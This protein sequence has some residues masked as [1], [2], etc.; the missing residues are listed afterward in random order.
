MS[1]VPR[2]AKRVPRPYRSAGPKAR[3]LKAILQMIIAFTAMI[4]LGIWLIAMMRGDDNL[5]SAGE[6]S[7]GLFTGIGLA[8]AGAAVI[9]LAY[10]LYTD[11]PDEA[12]N[13][14]MLGVA[15]ALLIQLGRV[16]KFDIWQAGAALLYVTA[17]GGLF[18]IRKWLADDEPNDSWSPVSAW[19]R[20]QRKRRLRHRLRA[21]R[22]APQQRGAAQDDSEALAQRN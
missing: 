15:A 17:L 8:L 6:L 13:P 19:R 12:L 4:G 3:Y 7:D 16:E 5:P 14:V 21:D 10:T 9:E 18:A 22:K 20:Y 11:G 1:T 2:R